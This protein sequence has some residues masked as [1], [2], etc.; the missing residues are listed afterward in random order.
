MPSP[1]SFPTA[2]QGQSLG[3]KSQL[4]WAPVGHWDVHRDL[5]QCVWL[6][7]SVITWLATCPARLLEDRTGTSTSWWP[8]GKQCRV[9]GSH[10]Q[11][12]KLK[13]MQAG[14]GRTESVQGQSWEPLWLSWAAGKFVHNSRD[15]DGEMQGFPAGVLRRNEQR[16]LSQVII[17]WKKTRFEGKT[18]D[19]LEKSLL[20]NVLSQSIEDGIS[21]FLFPNYSFWSW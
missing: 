12:G 20:K 19:V 13:C 5:Q 4:S 8:E 1:A 9:Q 14:E 16:F 10:T 11:K 7:F 18:L 21:S 17:A 6:E 2:P 15:G 3:R